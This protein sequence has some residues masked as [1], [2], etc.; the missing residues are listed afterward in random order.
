MVAAAREAVL[1]EWTHIRAVEHAQALPVLCC[2]ENMWGNVV[3]SAEPKQLELLPGCGVAVL[4][5]GRSV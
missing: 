1:V 4:S 3:G 5:Q 2:A